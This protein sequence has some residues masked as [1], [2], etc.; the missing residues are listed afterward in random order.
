[1]KGDNAFTVFSAINDPWDLLHLEELCHLKTVPCVPGG[2]V[3]CLTATLTLGQALRPP[4]NFIGVLELLFSITKELGCNWN[5]LE[6]VA[7]S[8]Y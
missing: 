2:K 8:L 6:V 7:G 4:Y 1:V 3:D 5:S